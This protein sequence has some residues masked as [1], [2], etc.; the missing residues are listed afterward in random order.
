MS[1]EAAQV[2]EDLVDVPT[3]ATE[4]GVTTQ[5]VYGWI[6]EGRLCAAREWPDYRPRVRRVDVVAVVEQRLR[7]SSRGRLCGRARETLR[8][9]LAERRP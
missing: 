6:R 8:A 5:C 7:S 4:L 9:W 3:V 2:A 1:T